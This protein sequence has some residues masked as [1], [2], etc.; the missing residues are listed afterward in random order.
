MAEKPKRIKQSTEQ[1]KQLETFLASLGVANTLNLYVYRSDTYLNI[2]ILLPVLSVDLKWF[3]KNSEAPMHYIKLP[4]GYYVNKYGITKLLAQSKQAVAFLLQDY[5]YELLYITE[6]K[7]YVKASD[8]K[9]RDALADCLEDSCALIDELKQNNTQL[10]SDYCIQEMENEE[11]KKKILE[12]ESA[13]DALSKEN[14]HLKDVANKLAKYV[15]IKHP[16]EQDLPDFIEDTIPD[17]CINRIME[18][19]SLAK[20]RLKHGR[21]SKEEPSVL[22]V[23]RSAWPCCDSLDLYNW[24]LTNEIPSGTFIE[25][26]KDFALDECGDPPGDYIYHTMV[27]NNKK[28]LLSVIF[29]IAPYT[30]WDIEQIISAF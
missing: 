30:I 24:R 4:D 16:N 19:A 2:D 9:T 1:T 8:L 21:P 5:L 25:K 10:H 20:Y 15:R 3:I 12:L 23:L 17:T 14:E 6:T 22:V 29:D 7:G 18:E 11:H 28:K 27:L 26:S 13:N